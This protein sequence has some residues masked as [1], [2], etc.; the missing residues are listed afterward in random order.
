MRYARCGAKQWWPRRARGLS[1]K[2]LAETFYDKSEMV[3]QAVFL[4]IRHGHHA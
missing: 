2:M 3:M 1:Q 4:G